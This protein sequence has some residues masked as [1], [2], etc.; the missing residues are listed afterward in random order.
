MIATTLRAG[1][2]LAALAGPAAAG[3]L[4]GPLMFP[5]SVTLSGAVDRGVVAVPREGQA[6]AA[7][8]SVSASRVPAVYEAFVAAFPSS[9]LAAEA[10]ARAEALRE[11]ASGS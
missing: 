2:A 8:E 10:R 7:W 3:T 1:L 6:A 4:N 5:A 9:P 11:A